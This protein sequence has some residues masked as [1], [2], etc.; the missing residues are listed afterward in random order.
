MQNKNNG[1]IS[2]YKKFEYYFENI[3]KSEN[4]EKEINLALE[5]FALI[6]KKGL[7]RSE[8]KDYIVR[9]GD[10]VNVLFNV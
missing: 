7:L 9:D 3:K 5:R 8:G 10:V 2:R 1:G 6:V 4:S